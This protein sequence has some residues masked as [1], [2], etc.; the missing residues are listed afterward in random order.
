MEVWMIATGIIVWG[1][2]WLIFAAHAD[3]STDVYNWFK[4][5]KKCY[6]H[7]LK[8][9]GVK[10][11]IKEGSNTRFRYSFLWVPLWPIIVPLA[12]I[13]FIERNT[14]G[15][16]KE[17]YEAY[18]EKKKVY[19]K[20]DDIYSFKKYDTINLKNGEQVTLNFFSQHQFSDNENNVYDWIEAKSNI[21]YE[22]RKREEHKNIKF[23]LF[24]Q[25]ADNFGKI[26]DDF[27]KEMAEQRKII[28][29]KINNAN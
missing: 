16:Q 10:R 25:Q 19:I 26:V 11:T 18:K 21:S 9:I 27:Q 3:F 29:E 5:E 6:M 28:F 23:N 4:E 1:I 20:L 7:L 17:K 12:F 13:L 2:G 8:Y 22:A 14:I 24:R 15:K